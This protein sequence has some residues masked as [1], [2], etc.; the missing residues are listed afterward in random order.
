MTQRMIGGA[1][2]N[3][4][5]NNF[6]KARKLQSGLNHGGMHVCMNFCSL[7]QFFFPVGAYGS[8]SQSTC[9]GN[10]FQNIELMIH[11]DSSFSRSEEFKQK[12]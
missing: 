11:Y 12:S 3:Q 2:Q 5:N 10:N 7:C 8:S 1:V 4:N 6:R 9:H